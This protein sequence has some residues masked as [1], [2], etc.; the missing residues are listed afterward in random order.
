MMPHESVLRRQIDLPVIATV[1]GRVCDPEI[2]HELSLPS[3]PFQHENR[4][5]LSQ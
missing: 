5:Q 1:A 4:R 3:V 2:M